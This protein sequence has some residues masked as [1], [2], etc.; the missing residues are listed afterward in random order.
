[1]NNKKPMVGNITKDIGWYYLGEGR[2]SCRSVSSMLA[3]LEECNDQQQRKRFFYISLARHG[4]SFL[5]AMEANDISPEQAIECFLAL[6]PSNWF[7][8]HRA[9]MES[10][11]TEEETVW[12]E[13][14]TEEGNYPK[15]VPFDRH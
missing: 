4:E 6:K 7:M 8:N 3:T 5:D 15:F 12:E 9:G 14:T 2:V 13:F 1:M 11:K 10:E